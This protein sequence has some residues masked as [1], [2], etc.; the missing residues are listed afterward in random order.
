MT[1]RDLTSDELWLLSNS[2]EALDRLYDQQSSVTDV[3]A[4]PF[5]TTL[6]LKGTEVHAAFAHAAQSLEQILKAGLT[7]ADANRDA[8]IVTDPLRESGYGFASSGPRIRNVMMTG[9]SGGPTSRCNRPPS[10]AAQRPS[11]YT[12]KRR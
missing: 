7:E 5:A 6:A 11:R 10:A 9:S 3:H 4:L 8:L 12:D 1:H 2:L